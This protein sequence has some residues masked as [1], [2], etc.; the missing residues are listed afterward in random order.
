MEETKPV[1]T[2]EVST[3]EAGGA[4][5]E[6]EAP[7]EEKNLQAPVDL[8]AVSDL[9]DES[10]KAIEK[11]ERK[12]VALKRNIK[13]GSDEDLITELETVKAELAEL[14]EA[15]QLA[16]DSDVTEL[17]AMRKK[18]QELR[19]TLI[20]KSTVSTSAGSNQDEL[21]PEEDLAKSISAEILPV[22]E[23]YS[24]KYKMPMKE[25]I[26]AHN[27]ASATNQPL[28]LYLRQKKRS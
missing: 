1:E 23:G 17:Q 4:Q 9:L 22:L 25:V 12:I 16:E 10:D 2:L 19:A 8:Q 6:P 11:A 18:N 15:K 13:S 5:T 20:A 3:P 7:V 21:R 28:G 24:K 26:A 14:K 27:A